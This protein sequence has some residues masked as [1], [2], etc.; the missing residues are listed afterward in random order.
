MARGG[1]LTIAITTNQTTSRICAAGAYSVSVRRLEGPSG[2]AMELGKTLRL[3][4]RRGKITKD[5]GMEERGQV[6]KL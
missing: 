4:S 2:D 6:D 3:A 1:R 5:G